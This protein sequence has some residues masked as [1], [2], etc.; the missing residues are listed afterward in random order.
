MAKKTKSTAPKKVKASQTPKPNPKPVDLDAL[1][2][3]NETSANVR[4][5]QAYLRNRM[6]GIK[7]A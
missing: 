6:K 7:L 2:K 4:E 5:Y 1:V 3:K